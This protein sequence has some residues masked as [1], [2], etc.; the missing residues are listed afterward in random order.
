[1]LGRVTVG[2]FFLLLV[3]GNLVAGLKAGLAC[4]DWPLCHGKILPPFRIDIY[5]EFLHRVI[6][7]VAAGFLVVLSWRRY[8]DYRGRARAVPLLAVGLLAGE[9]VLGGAVVLLA[10]PVQLTTVHF[11]I[12]LVVFLLAVYMASFDGVWEPPGFSLSGRSAL[13]FGVGALVFLLAALGAYVRHSDAGLACTD[14]PACLG[15]ILPGAFTGHI[16]VHFSHRVLAA[17]VFLTIVALYASIALDPRLRASRGLARGLLF[18]A[19]VQVGIG[20]AVVLSKLYFLATGLHLAVALG[21]L[22]LLFHLWAR[23]VKREEALP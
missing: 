1:M 19:L 16:L 18:L 10:V 11:M 15:G 14:W 7:A 13:F 3:W 21:M 23:E 6:A 17:L 8:R 9:V 2:L 12:G 5:M 22:V 4:P 20:G